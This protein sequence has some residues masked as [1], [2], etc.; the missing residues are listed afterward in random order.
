MSCVLYCRR[1]E[2]VKAPAYPGRGL[3]THPISH[4]PAQDL[5]ILLYSRGFS[6]RI[7]DK[8]TWS[9]TQ[10]KKR[11]SYIHSHFAGLSGTEAGGFLRFQM[12]LGSTGG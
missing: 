12:I 8:K 11:S 10:A 6:M 7:E 5:A 9:F 1:I 4:L 3:L 2:K